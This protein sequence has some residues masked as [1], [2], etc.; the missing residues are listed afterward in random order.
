MLPAGYET[1]V[2][3]ILFEH[4]SDERRCQFQIDLKP[5]LPYAKVGPVSEFGIPYIDMIGAPSYLAGGKDAL[6]QLATDS[7]IS[8]AWSGLDLGYKQMRSVVA[9]PMAAIALNPTTTEVRSFFNSAPS[10]G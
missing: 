3:A 4:L 9:D 10:R 1:M 8:F 5:M 6:A 7:A 2:K